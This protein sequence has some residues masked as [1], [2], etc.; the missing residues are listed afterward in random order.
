MAWQPA[1]GVELAAATWAEQT[2]H[3]LVVLGAGV[4]DHAPAVAVSVAPTMASPDTA[5][6]PVTLGAVATGAA[7]TAAVDAVHTVVAPRLLVAVTAPT[8][9]L[10]TASAVIAH[11]AAVAPGMTEQFAARVV[12]GVATAA[13]QRA[14][15]Y[16]RVG[17]GAPDQVP[18]LVVRVLPT[19]V[20]PATP[21]ATSFAGVPATPTVDTDHLVAAP[22]MFFAVTAKE[23]NLPACAALTAKLAAAAP[24][25][26]AHPAGWLVDDAVTAAEH[27]Y[28]A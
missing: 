20:S 3:A 9:N 14:Q 26:G 25:M 27:E 1:G 4:P 8:T 22:A 24:A 16:V 28:Q 18:S 5:G 7:L 15:P 17:A 12:E 11:V 23:T 21:G 19:V 2:Y 10:P 6:S 13:E